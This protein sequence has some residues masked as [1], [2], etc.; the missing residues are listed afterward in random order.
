[1]PLFSG[2]KNNINNNS[3]PSAPNTDSFIRTILNYE[4]ESLTSPSSLFDIATTSKG[5]RI[6]T[7]YDIENNSNNNDDDDVNRDIS[8]SSLL[9]QNLVRAEKKQGVNTIVLDSMDIANSGNDRGNYGN[10][11]NDHIALWSKSIPALL[12]EQQYNNGTA[13]S[14]NNSDY[15]NKTINYIEGTLRVLLKIGLIEVMMLVY[16]GNMVMI[17]NT[18][19]H[20]KAL[21]WSY[22]KEKSR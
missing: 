14:N 13:D 15:N 7:N 2:S 22:L 19:C 10:S 20:L 4:N 11:R 1:M 9:S 3:N 12:Q 21:E 18:T 5:D 6:L 16:Y 8:L 17:Q